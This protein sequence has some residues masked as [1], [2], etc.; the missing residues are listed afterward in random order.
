MPYNGMSGGG[1]R[2]AHVPGEPSDMASYNESFSTLHRI[3]KQMG[4]L[5]D[6]LQRGPKQ[7]RVVETNVKNCEAEVAQAKETYKQARLASDEKQ[8]QLKSREARLKDLQGKLNTAQNNKEFQLLKEQ[9]AADVQ[10]NSVLSDEILE[11][12]ERLDV[13]QANIKTAEANLA[14]TKEDMAK[15]RKRVDDQQQ[16]LESE[17]A[18]VQAELRAEEDKLD[19]DFKPSYQRL[20]KALGADCLAPVEG[21]C[22]GG[23]SQTLQPQTLNL[24]GL[25]KPTFCK[26]CGR[27]MYLPQ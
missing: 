12:L 24:L 10:A 23:C 13:L 3:H 16:G 18:R 6:R 9:M 1:I 20:A 7:I 22:C 27:L 15:V 2:R 19:G 8:L 14:K 4:D 17:L 5:Q 21:E 25:D 11:A 26:S